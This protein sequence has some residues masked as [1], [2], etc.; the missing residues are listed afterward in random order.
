MRTVKAIKTGFYNGRRRVGDTF[1][2]P[3]NLRLYSWMEL[4][5][6]EPQSEEKKTLTLPHKGGAK[7]GSEKL[8]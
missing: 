2:Y 5:T 8:V 4:V 1:A 6:R 7:D 3:D